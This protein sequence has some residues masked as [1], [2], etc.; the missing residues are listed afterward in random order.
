VRQLTL[1]GAEHAAA[2]PA[3]PAPRD[4][5][6]SVDVG[7][8]AAGVFFDVG[9]RD[10][11]VF[12]DVGPRVAGPRPEV[13][14][15]E[16]MRRAARLL[17]TDLVLRAGA[18]TG[19][20]H[21]L[22]SA[23]VHLL[24]GTTRLG[25]R[26]PVSALLLLTFS[27]K[28]AG[29]LQARVRARLAELAAA[30]RSDAALEEAYARTGAQPLGG[31]AWRAALA[32]LPAARITTF[33]GFAAGLVR[34]HAARL[35]LDPAFTVLAEDDAAHLLD[36]AA[37]EVT[38]AALDGS[39]AV[40][41]LVRELDY[42][43]APGGRG[44]GLV[45]HVAELVVRLREEGRPARA[46]RGDD[47]DGARAELE[48][49]RHVYLAAL[50]DLIAALGGRG[51]ARV[52]E[53]FHAL[54]RLRGAAAEALNGVNAARAPFDEPALAAVHEHSKG[55]L[56]TPARQEAAARLR[57][58]EATL[59]AAHVGLRAAPLIDPL[60]GLVEAT[61]AAYQAAKQA[62]GV[63]DF[64][65]LLLSARHV[66]AVCPGARA[67]EQARVGALL[68]DEL[69]DTN[70][71]QDELLGAVRAPGT[72]LLAV[73]DPKQSIYEFRGAD[74]AVF[75]EV[76][77]RVERGGGQALALVESRRGRAP[78]VAF[79]NQ[80]FARALRGGE[81]AFELAWSPAG[82][83]LHAHRGGE[84]PCVELVEHGDGVEA[85]AVARR[86]RALVAGGAS[87]VGDPATP[88][89]V[90]LGDIAILLRRFTHLDEYLEELRRAGLPH[91]VVNGRG[92]YQ[93][94]EVRDLVN[95]LV[96]LDDPDDSLALLGVLRSPLCGLS[97]AALVTL[98]DGG[99]LSHAALGARAASLA[100]AE[101]ARLEAFLVLDARLRAHGD[102]LGA[103][104][105]LRLLVDATDLRAVLASTHAGE[106]RVANLERL[107]A[108][109]AA[110]DDEGQGDRRSLVRRL[111]AE[112]AR[113]RSLTAPA[114]VVG[115]HEDVV[116]IMTIHQAKG[117]EFPVVF[118]PECGASERADVPAVS[119]DRA[120]GLGLRLRVGAERVASPRALRADEV[121]KQRARA[122]SLRL[123]Y[124]A[125]TRARDLLVLS[126]A[127]G[128]GWRREVDGL[129][130][131]RGGLPH[132]VR[133]VP[134]VPL[135]A[136][137]D[138]PVPAGS[139]LAPAAASGAAA[140][141]DPAAASG[142][143]A[144]LDPAAA[145]GAVAPPDP[146]AASGAA[147]PPARAA[148]SDA[149]APLAPAAASGAAAP[150]ARAAAS[151]AAAP[152]ATTVSATAAAPRPS[153]AAFATA[154]APPTAGTASATSLA[155]DSTAPT[156]SALPAATTAAPPASESAPA[157]PAAAVARL[158]RPPASGARLIVA[159]VTELGDFAACP[160]RYHLRHEV[161]LSEFPT[162]V[163][164]VDGDTVLTEVLDE[165]DHDAE[166]PS[167]A[168]LDAA[169]RG[170]LAHLLLERV[171]LSA[172]IAARSAELNALAQEAGHDPQAP[173][174]QAVRRQVEQFLDTRFGRSLAERPNGAVLREV[175]FALAASAEG[176][177]KLLVKG[178]ID[179]V[180]LDGDTATIVDYKLMR[181]VAEG[182]YRAQLLTYAAAARALWRPA[183]IQVGLALLGSRDPTPELVEVHARDL[184]VTVANLAQL[185]GALARSRRR[186]EYEG[187]PLATCRTL[188]CGYRA[189]CHGAA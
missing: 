19:K 107:L 86:I 80:L 167:D 20:T 148:A 40:A 188:G 177:T 74:V 89:P 142:A 100:P 62:R 35:G 27:E 159:P 16:A 93:A 110:F 45:D 161:G 47:E 57:A 185:A 85:R 114:Q 70:G 187:R 134:A 46:V 79:V 26:L 147:A 14:V 69:Q 25:H 125:A 73:G 61:G 179:L 131:E 5:G 60:L 128:K 127:P 171:R 137:T 81:H 78:L 21:T 43:R 123:F 172:P 119:Y 72:P 32:A 129:L 71:L 1:F 2:P 33:H 63:L 169:E 95:A 118:V 50:D 90:R 87:L 65:D 11:G 77:A 138:W 10:A 3:R 153:A 76:A 183:R 39:A 31:E 44:R 162:I 121:R 15:D 101:R 38:L 37:R 68:V 64:A 18:G 58:A 12:F 7:P 113:E 144:P 115:E 48:R 30:P 120:A 53:R 164:R 28:A 55:S 8:P 83:P 91:H 94:Q 163:E 160:R 141:L 52:V 23:V 66:L 152:P 132:L 112:T 139:A 154:A 49:A 124:V 108:Q 9:P 51:S 178:Q 143:A 130:A 158:L 170:T 29:E 168:T 175:P 176:R 82:D 24:A 97:D 151:D 166:L 126:G 36:T 149:A 103:G 189:R 42:A 106:E 41:T 105:V 135:R 104:G 145:S 116:R 56:G 117:L 13:A 155:P 67:E 184:D 180:V 146:A 84:G 140:P 157:D 102:R 98:A 6:T 92:F 54:Q 22:V 99:R 173:D 59:T 181:S 133:G 165:D 109:A 156:D 111:Q 34:R 174:V 17:E 4:S 186:G 75:G 122:E 150:P 88:R 96:L 136:L 182:A